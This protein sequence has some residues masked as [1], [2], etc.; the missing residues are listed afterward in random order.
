MWSEK[1]VNT[2]RYCKTVVEVH[3][4]RCTENDACI[5][6]SVDTRND[7]MAVNRNN[8]WAS[9]PVHQVH[10]TSAVVLW[11]HQLLSLCLY[12]SSGDH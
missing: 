4:A 10:H 7:K 6:F 1:Y 11:Y 9:F 3:G 8:V 12:L 2:W 5:L